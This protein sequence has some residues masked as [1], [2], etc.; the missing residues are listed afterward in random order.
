MKIRAWVTCKT[1]QL[2][3]VAEVGSGKLD[4]W[5]HSKVNQSPSSLFHHLT[6]HR[7]HLFGGGGEQ[8]LYSPDWQN[9]YIVHYNLEILVLT[10]LSAGV[11][12]VSYVLSACSAG[13]QTQVLVY[14]LDQLSCIL[15]PYKTYFLPIFLSSL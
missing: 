6:V 10:L 12:G 5:S 13:D 4:L 14:E 11:T 1:N 8:S 7:T 2:P 3:G 15:S 9:H